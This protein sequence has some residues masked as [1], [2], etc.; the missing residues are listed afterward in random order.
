MRIVVVLISIALFVSCGT[1]QSRQR[2]LTSASLMVKM[3][4]T[5][6]DGEQVAVLM[7]CEK[8]KCFNP[9]RGDSGE[10]FY[11]KNYADLYNQKVKEEGKGQKIKMAL[12]GITMAATAAGAAL[13]IKSDA[14]RWRI[15]DLK[16]KIKELSD[17]L[18]KKIRKE[19][20]DGAKKIRKDIDELASK[21]KKLEAID[22]VV[23]PSYW[24]VL[25]L[26][27]VGANALAFVPGIAEDTLWQNN[28]RALADLFIHGSAVKVTKDELIDL[29]SIIAKQV[30]ARVDVEVQSY[31][32]GI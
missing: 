15:V 20:S 5:Q 12:L 26:S 23:A 4:E 30:P 6:V 25:G 19:N 11:F 32:F 21:Q 9:L 10:D 14:M 8:E 2:M 24:A 7:L 22:S 29:F 16:D 31:L 18:A 28:K 3:E 27:A 1:E 13:Y 17:K